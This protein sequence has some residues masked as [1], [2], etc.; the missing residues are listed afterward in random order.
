M[1]KDGL[2]ED[3]F[4]ALIR[5]TIDEK[6]GGVQQDAARAWGISQQ[7]LCDI[8]ARRR[9]PAKAIQNAIGFKVE[10]RYRYV[11]A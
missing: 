8:L 1:R 5:R 6:F 4:V 3:E 7:F 2:T 10:V 9:A 11:R